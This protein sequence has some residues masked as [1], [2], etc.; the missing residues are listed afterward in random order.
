ME[1]VNVKVYIGK[2]SKNE[3]GSWATENHPVKI[4]KPSK[5]W[6]LFLSNAKLM[7][8]KV[9]L[10]EVLKE[11]VVHGTKKV[12]GQEVATQKH[13]YEAVKSSNE[14]IEEIKAIYISKV[15]LTED[16]IRIAGLEAKLE[17]LSAAKE[18]VK[19]SKKVVA[20]IP[21]DLNDD[22]DEI[23]ELRIEYFGLAEKKPHHLWK[24][25]KLKEE[26][27]KLKK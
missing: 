11:T 2:L 16:Q 7:Y 1:I 22:I 19:E 26:I 25:D 9:E 10:T 13:K 4:R 20:N 24:E 6:G 5:E 18:P 14:I 23:E 3:D 15:E 8:S 12:K 17:A 27:E 21:E